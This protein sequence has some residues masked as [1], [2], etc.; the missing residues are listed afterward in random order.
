MKD[1]ILLKFEVIDTGR[2]FTTEDEHKMFKPFSQLKQVPKDDDQFDEDV[3]DEIEDAD[4][5]DEG[6][7]QVVKDLIQPRVTILQNVVALS[8]LQVL[9]W[10]L[11]FL[12][13]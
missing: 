1:T 13:N 7:L 10:D 4:D 8:F 9:A 3:D 6:S 2:G 12:G 11:L 5:S